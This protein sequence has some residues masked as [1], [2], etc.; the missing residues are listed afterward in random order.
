M[1]KSAH[2]IAVYYDQHSSAWTQCA[3]LIAS[4]NA[5]AWKSIYVH[6]EHSSASVRTGLSNSFPNCIAPILSA[7]LFFTPRSV[8][9]RCVRPEE[10]FAYF[11]LD[12]AELMLEQTLRPE[13]TF[14]AAMLAYPFARA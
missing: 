3:K 12:G 6:D 5:R 2:H 4:F 10:R 13:R 8:A 7:A 1:N 14:V 11:D 9:L